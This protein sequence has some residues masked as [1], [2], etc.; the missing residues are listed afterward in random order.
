MQ[1]SLQ[2]TQDAEYIRLRGLEQKAAALTSDNSVLRHLYFEDMYKRVDSITDATDATFDWLLADG[3]ASPNTN[4][5]ANTSDYENPGASNEWYDERRQQSAA[6]ISEFLEHG[7]GVFF[8]RGKPGSGKSTFMKYLTV[9]RGKQEV[10]RKLRKWSG[11]KKLVRVTT[12]FLLHGTPLQ[13]SLE[14]FY[15][16]FFFELLCQFPDLTDICFPNQFTRELPEDSYGSSFRLETLQEAWKKLVSFKHHESL[17][18]CVSIDG[19]DELEGSSGDRLKFA[20]ILNE[21]A[22]SGD[23]KIICSGRPSAEFNIVFNQP[24]QIINLQDLTRPDIRKILAKRFEGASQFSDLTE[25]NIQSLINDISHQSEGVILWAVLVGKNLEDDIIHGKSL[26]AMKSTLKMLPPGIEE[27][28]DG[29]WQDLRRDAHQK[30]MLQTIYDLL[31]LYDGE[32]ALDAINL[33]WLEDALFD[34]DFPYNKPIQ[35]LSDDELSARLAKA[36]AQLVQHTKHFVEII[37]FYPRDHHILN[38][39]CDFIHRSAQE[40]LQSKLDRIGSVPAPVDY[41]LHLDLRLCLILQMSIWVSWPTAGMVR[42][43]MRASHIGRNGQAYRQ[44][45][46]HQIHYRFMKKLHELREA[47]RGFLSGFL[48]DNSILDGSVD[49]Y[50]QPVELGLLDRLLPRVKN[51]DVTVF[52][53][54]VENHQI[55]YIARI[56]NEQTQ[57]LDQEEVRLGLLI[58]VNGYSPNHEISE[59]LVKHGANPD[60]LIQTYSA[61]TEE[62]QDKI[63]LWLLFC[64]MFA[65]KVSRQGAGIPGDDSNTNLSDACLILE[66]FLCLG[67]GVDVKFLATTTY[68]WHFDKDENNFF[69]M[70]LAQVVRLAKPHNMSR[71]LMLLQQPVP[72]TFCSL[73]QRFANCVLQQQ[74][75]FRTLPQGADTIPYRTVS[76][77]YLSRAGWEI[78]AAFEGEHEVRRGGCYDVPGY[79]RQFDIPI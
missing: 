12:M 14:G 71:L 53:L 46:V 42:M 68:R 40:F 43:F 62:T 20:R 8:L 29:M 26:G 6:K 9:G 18:I 25:D 54:A 63:P 4:K 77:E 22:Q 39:A 32:Y 69:G 7:G 27:L 3:S 61:V 1:N 35:I 2:Q 24:H 5:P 57:T 48:S 31:T 73:V 66:R 76:D 70:D 47:R 65:F 10:D 44:H 75:P 52:H 67:Y 28:Y 21:W 37:D 36:R 30:L 11:Q 74:F 23:V 15:R 49:E 33:S 50:W 59:L 34:D 58:C 72:V 16:T 13:R 79:D 60:S 51:K 55:D 41:I 45:P 17:R 78:L 56:L 38:R 64:F 19:M